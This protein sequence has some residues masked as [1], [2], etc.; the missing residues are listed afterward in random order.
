M[1]LPGCNLP[2]CEVH[3]ETKWPILQDIFKFLGP[4]L[5]EAVLLLSRCSD[6]ERYLGDFPWI[7]KRNKRVNICTV[8]TPNP[9]KHI[10][11]TGFDYYLGESNTVTSLVDLMRRTLTGER[12]KILILSKDPSDQRDVSNLFEVVA[13]Q[14]PRPLWYSLSSSLKIKSLSGSSDHLSLC[15]ELVL[16]NDAPIEVEE[17]EAMDIILARLAGEPRPTNPVRITFP[18]VS[19]ISSVE[20]GLLYKCSL[21]WWICALSRLCS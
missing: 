12:Q 7:V 5:K 17:V 13:K 21:N 8:W 10:D 6:D 9:A 2:G 15:N 14:T 4:S 1:D 20:S 19:S 3:T 18:K 11:V 16:Y